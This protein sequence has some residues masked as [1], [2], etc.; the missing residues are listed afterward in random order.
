[1]GWFPVMSF[2]SALESAWN[3]EKLKN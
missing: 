1:L 3:W 2:E